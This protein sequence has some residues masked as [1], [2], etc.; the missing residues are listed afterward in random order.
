MLATGLALVGAPMLWALTSALKESGL[1]APL[2]IESGT[3]IGAATQA[4][5]ANQ[6]RFFSLAITLATFGW[7]SAIALIATAL[8][9][10]AAWLLRARG[11]RFLPLLGAPLLLPNYLAFGA[12]NLM[13]APGTWF[14][15]LL[16][17]SSRG[18]LAWLPSAAGRALAIGGLGIWAAPIAAVVLAVWLRRVDSQ[19]WEQVAL[20][21]HPGRWRG[22]LSILRHKVSLSMPGLAA[23]VLLITVLMLG[24]AIPLHVAR[25][26][27][28]TIRVWLAMDLLPQDRQ[29]RAWV[30]AWPMLLAA[31][32]ASWWIAR[33]LGAAETSPS[34]EPARLSPRVVGRGAAA[35]AIGLV[36]LGALVPFVLF[37]SHIASA[38]GFVTFMR[39]YRSQFM[40]SGLVAAGVALGAVALMLLSWVGTLAGG[41]A[42]R[43]V[44]SSAFLFALGALI[45]G[46]MLAVWSGSLVRASCPRLEDSPWLLVLMHLARFGIV[47]IALG[48][49]LA[50][51]EPREQRDQRRLDG[52]TGVWGLMRAAVAGHARAL[53]AGGI[54]AGVL[55]LHEIESSII[56]QPPGIDTVSR[57]ILNQLHFARTQELS[58]A[59][60]LLLSVGLAGG[61]LA[62]WLLRPEEPRD[63]RRA[64]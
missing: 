6:L 58:A 52:A 9:W 54:I 8:G 18:E 15:D 12:F 14:G 5:A 38:G 20:D 63:R 26:E 62:L 49:W 55:S 43:M 24:S 29:W 28:L 39:L 23:A 4:P 19:T 16:E 7:A 11:W 45:P 61:V 60:I 42:R 44:R 1:L 25:V 10:P 30:I 3:A 34:A 36:A 17:R 57:A 41:G 22:G 56:L 35:G 27:T 51:S 37:V 64:D 21:A 48:C 40:N 46:V 2:P 32:A 47:P 50:A 31:I 53:F 33:E 59:G 13:R